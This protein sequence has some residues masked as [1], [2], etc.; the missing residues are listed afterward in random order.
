MRGEDKYL[1]AKSK[2]N[3]AESSSCTPKCCT[4]PPIL[5]PYRLSPL[6]VGTQPPPLSTH[7]LTALHCPTPRL[8]LAR[9]A[10]SN[11]QGD[12]SND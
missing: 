7:T 12:G 5:V 11:I 2:T 9:A 4:L 6:T 10:F 1:H 3:N 8:K